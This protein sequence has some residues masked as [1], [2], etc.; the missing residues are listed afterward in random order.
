MDADARVRIALPALSGQLKRPAH[1]T[2]K[3][4]GI[5][6][7]INAIL[8]SIVFIQNKEFTLE[9]FYIKLDITI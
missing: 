4:K 1:F 5:S 8:L 7:K 3:E 9:M 2:S 6:L